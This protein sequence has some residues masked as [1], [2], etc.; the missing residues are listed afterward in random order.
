MAG[1]SIFR[2]VEMEDLFSL[3]NSSN[4][5]QET[6]P[7]TV[8]MRPQSLQEFVGQEHLLAPGKFLRRSIEA[9]RLASLILYG[10]PG[11]GKTSLG[12]VISKTTNAH[13]TVLNAAFSNVAEIK[14]EINQARLRLK[15]SQKKTV[16]FIDEFHRLNRSQQDILIPDTETLPLTL[17][18]LSA[19]P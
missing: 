8:R 2:K 19:R 15:T 14:K 9:D 7:L 16:L 10:P 17:F 3:N 11:T 18:S 4:Q 6:L 1:I 5:K 13:F 12:F